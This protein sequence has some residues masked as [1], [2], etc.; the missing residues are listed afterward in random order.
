MPLCFLRKANQ[1]FANQ[2]LERAL[3]PEPSPDPSRSFGLLYPDLLVTHPLQPICKSD[4][5]ATPNC[6]VQTLTSLQ[7]LLFV[8]L[9]NVNTQKTAQNRSKR[10]VKPFSILQVKVLPQQEVS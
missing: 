3:H 5:T 6:T 4:L 8:S 1:L 10:F 7:V 2:L 9:I